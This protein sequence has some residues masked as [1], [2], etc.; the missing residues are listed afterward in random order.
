MLIEDRARLTSLSSSAAREP[1]PANQGSFFDEDVDRLSFMRAPL[2]TM[3]Y[4]LK[5]FVVEFAA[6][7]KISRRHVS[8]AIA[9]G[10]FLLVPTISKAIPGAHLDFIVAFEEQFFWY[11]RWF[12]LGV[13]SSIGLGT[14]AHTFLL[15]LGPMIA[16]TTT[17]AYTCM[18]LDFDLF[19]PQR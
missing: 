13:L 2:L 15:F 17:A 14:G 8:L 7:K 5:F 4:C 10:L 3:K 18:S 9:F 12:I 16:E 6:L 1:N 19:G 11:A